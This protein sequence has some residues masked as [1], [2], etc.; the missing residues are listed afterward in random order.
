MAIYC[1]A[2]DPMLGKPESWPEALLKKARY[3]SAIRDGRDWWTQIC[4]LSRDRLF[5]PDDVGRDF[6]DARRV[7]EPYVTNTTVPS[8]TVDGLLDMIGKSKLGIG[9]TPVR[10]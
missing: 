2:M 10:Q 9:K 1:L 5:N 6:A 3:R 4:S 7:L 8:V